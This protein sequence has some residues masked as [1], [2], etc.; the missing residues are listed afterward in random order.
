M[1]IDGR[2]L[3]RS[4]INLAVGGGA[5]P[6]G[7]PALMAAQSRLVGRE[8]EPEGGVM[9]G[10]LLLAL[11]SLGTRSL[12]QQRSNERPP[13]PNFEGWPVADAVLVCGGEH[14]R[15]HFASVLVPCCQVATLST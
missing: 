2:P 5:C 8:H 10:S 7:W 9:P 1:Q 14:V 6:P 12:V 11:R 13:P 4:C 3:Q 15:E